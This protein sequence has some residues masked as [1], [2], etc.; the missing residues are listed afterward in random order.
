MTHS[1][2]ALKEI[3]MLS[4]I[5]IDAVSYKVETA[6]HTGERGDNRVRRMLKLLR[7]RDYKGLKAILA[8]PA[9]THDQIVKFVSLAK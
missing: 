3:T 7:S 1:A 2:R 9:T 5:I 8:N 6:T 4:Q